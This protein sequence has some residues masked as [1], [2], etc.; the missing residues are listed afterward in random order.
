MKNRITVLAPIVVALA[1]SALAP[2]AHATPPAKSEDRGNGNSAAEAV[3]AL[4]LSTTGSSNTA[5]GWFSLF[6]NTTGS[7]NT[8]DG[9]Q[10]LYSNT[11][12]TDNTA[13]GFQALYNNTGDLDLE[14]ASFNTA[15]GYQALYRNSGDV[16]RIRAGSFNTAIGH[17]ALYSN[18]GTGSEYG[19][20]NTAIG[21]QALYSNTISGGNTAI[22]YQ[23]L[24]SNVVDS[25]IE[26]NTAMGYQALQ[27]NT[28]G[29]NNTATGWLALA[30]TTTGYSNTAMGDYALGLNTTGSN[31]TAIGHV[32]LEKNT[33]G[34]QNTALGENAGYNVTTANN[35]ICIGS[36]VHGDNVDNTTW[37]GNVY[38]VFPVGGT[39][40]PVVVSDTGQLGSLA[41][42]QRFKK[43]IRTMQNA[44]EAVFSLRPITFHYKNDG[45]QTPQFG[46]IAE[47]VA[48][49]DPALVL[50]DKNGKPYTVRYEAVNVMLLNEFLKE[51]KKVEELEG[52]VASLATTVKEQSTQIE[53]VSEQL[54]ITRPRQRVVANDR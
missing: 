13:Y 2:V 11:G 20:Y 54:A 1:C 26:A 4:N 44:S 37:I 14:N 19:S 31:N 50:P 8:A 15:L 36:E 10:A 23:A 42:S 34:S 40:A 39:T 46:L 51:H 45:R 30:N 38:G 43:D 3:Q 5:H 35:V 28:T 33:T 21:Y 32:A 16:S 12:G 49:V 18:I 41:S 53:K 27:A 6:S 24:Y 17:Q 48:K 22:G 9:F 47:E 7:F 52:M 25:P 29:V